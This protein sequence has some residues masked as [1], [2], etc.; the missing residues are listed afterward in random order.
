MTPAFIT[1]EPPDPPVH[2]QKVPDKLVFG[3]ADRSSMVTCD[4]DAEES[5]DG[6]AV[7]LTAAASADSS[8]CT[9]A[10]ADSISTEGW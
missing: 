7:R 3:V 10:A 1:A 6:E 5:G 9:S 8:V 2:R 4:P